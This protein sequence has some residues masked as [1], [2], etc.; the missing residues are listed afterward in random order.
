M[1]HHANRPM[2]LSDVIRIVSAYSRNDHEVGLVVTD[3]LLRG[4]V[5]IHPRHSHRRSIRH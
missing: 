3:L 2:K 1:K 5:R 4:V